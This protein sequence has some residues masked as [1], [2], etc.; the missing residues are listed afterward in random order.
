VYTS[1][2]KGPFDEERFQNLR[3]GPPEERE[4]VSIGYIEY[5]LAVLKIWELISWFVRFDV[6]NRFL[7]RIH[8]G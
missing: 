1:C 3:P 5:P 7:N 8:I 6:C 2:F 4:E